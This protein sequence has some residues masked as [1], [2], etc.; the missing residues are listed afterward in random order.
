MTK[1]EI[2][3][4]PSCVKAYINQLNYPVKAYYL[5]DEDIISL[6]RGIVALEKDNEQDNKVD[7]TQV[8]RDLIYSDKNLTG[9]YIVTQGSIEDFLTA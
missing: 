6:E 9:E 1:L 4:L 8:T 7:L 5:L 3:S 2:L